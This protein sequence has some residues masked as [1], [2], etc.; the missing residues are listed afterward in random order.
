[1]DENRAARASRIFSHARIKTGEK[2]RA[3][4][5]ARGDGGMPAAH[6]REKD[7]GNGV[8]AG[9][10]KKKISSYIMPKPCI[11]QPAYQLKSVNIEEESVM[12]K[13]K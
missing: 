8:A 5:N 3:Q 11:S 6:M 9:G 12:K 13:E 1:M 10:M 2:N 4:R 7:S